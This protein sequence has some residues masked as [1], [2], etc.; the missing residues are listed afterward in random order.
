V[1][2]WGHQATIYSAKRA[3]HT[4]KPQRTASNHAYFDAWGHWAELFDD[5]PKVKDSSDSAAH[6]LW[7]AFQRLL[8]GQGLLHEVFPVS[9]EL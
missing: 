9:L 6:L 4:T 8:F 2:F 5:R 7:P 1:A 3:G